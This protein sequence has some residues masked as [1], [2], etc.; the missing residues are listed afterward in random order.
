[1]EGTIVGIRLM[2]LKKIL[3]NISQESRREI[4]THV[5]THCPSRVRDVTT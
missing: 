1:M 2:K 4:R 3:E 5:P